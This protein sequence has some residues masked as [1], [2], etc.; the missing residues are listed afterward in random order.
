[1]L[2]LWNEARVKLQRACRYHSKVGITKG[3]G[4]KGAREGR[5]DEEGP[6]LLRRTTKTGGL[7]V[8][9]LHPLGLQTSRASDYCQ[10][11]VFIRCSTIKMPCNPCAC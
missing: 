8:I 11:P 9:P 2:L 10:G 4:G 3:K 5:R 7:Q 1:M 6:H